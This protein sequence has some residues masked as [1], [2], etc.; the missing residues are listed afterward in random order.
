MQ[1]Q[2][3]SLE[4]SLREAHEKCKQLEEAKTELEKQLTALRAELEAEK[5]E[6][7]IKTDVIADLQG[8]PFA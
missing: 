7:S 1:K 2:T 4:L 5:R 6:R 8:E 3:Q